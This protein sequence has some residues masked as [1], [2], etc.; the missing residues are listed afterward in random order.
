MMTKGEGAAVETEVTIVKGLVS[1]TRKEIETDAATM[2]NIEA[3]GAVVTAG[4]TVTATEMIGTKEE[5]GM[6]SM[7]SANKND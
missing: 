3:T 4:A 5:S 2:T 7:M 1:D 6:S